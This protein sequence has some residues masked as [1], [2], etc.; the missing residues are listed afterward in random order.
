MKEPRTMRA[1]FA[2]FPAQLTLTLEIIIL[3]TFIWSAKRGESGKF[4]VSCD[5]TGLFLPQEKCSFLLV[6]HTCEWEERERERES[7]INKVKWVSSFEII[8]GNSSWED[9]LS[10]QRAEPTKLWRNRLFEIQWTTASGNRIISWEDK[11]KLQKHEKKCVQTDNNRF[12]EFNI[13]KAQK[14]R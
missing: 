1:W 4:L 7:F 12:V 5:A 2:L 8:V 9:P 11:R 3:P 14:K 10:A 6:V 13:L